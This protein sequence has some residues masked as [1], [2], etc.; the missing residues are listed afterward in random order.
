MSLRE[1]GEH[2]QPLPSVQ[3]ELPSDTCPH[4]WFQ[5]GQNS[6]H[7]AHVPAVINWGKGRRRRLAKELCF[8]SGRFLKPR[9]QTFTYISWARDASIVFP[10]S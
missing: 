4:R 9:Q 2:I 6:R 10:R 3:C 1:Q 7:H 5:E 8:V